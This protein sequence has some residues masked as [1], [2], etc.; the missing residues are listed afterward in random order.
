MVPGA[1]ADFERSLVEK[2]VKA[3]P[4]NAREGEAGRSTARRP[5]SLA[6]ERVGPNWGFL[7]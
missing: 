6:S 4:R 1:V 5:R 2:R 7:A 3:G